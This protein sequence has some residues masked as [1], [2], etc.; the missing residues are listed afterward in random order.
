MYK[1][2]T[3]FRER[4]ARWK[5][6]GESQYEAGLPKFATGTER[7]KDTEQQKAVQEWGGDWKTRTTA[8]GKSKVLQQW[9]AYGSRPKPQSSQEY[10][11]RRLAE[12]QKRTWLSDAADIAGGVKEAALSMT[13]YTAVPYFGAKVGQDILNG[14]VGAQTAIDAAFTAAPFMPTFTTELIKPYLNQATEKITSSIANLPPTKRLINYAMH[15]TD[16]ADPSPYILRDL[17]IKSYKDYGTPFTMQDLINFALDGTKDKTKL[18]NVLKYVITGKDKYRNVLKRY[19]GVDLIDPKQGYIGPKES[20]LFGKDMD[21]GIK[22]FPDYGIHSEYI[23]KRPDQTPRAVYST[24]VAYKDGLNSVDD[25]FITKTYKKT[26]SST[27]DYM[28]IVTPK[29]IG[30]YDAGGHLIQLGRGRD[31][32][33]YMRGQDL[34][35][36]DVHDYAKKHLSYYDPNFNFDIWKKQHPFLYYGLRGVQSAVKPILVRSKWT[37][38]QQVE[39]SSRVAP[40]FKQNLRKIYDG[41]T[42][43]FLN[44]ME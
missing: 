7:W 34:Y 36:F 13:P 3:E 33:L 28:S 24:G 38:L 31:C 37:P 17:G 10:T 8:A 29:G 25:S 21:A 23:A 4:F 9:N 2:P 14:S 1:D 35:K 40:D 26:L 27:D 6:T 18:K 32:K 19:S 22:V 20:V 44:I 39:N 43:T 16:A 5:S 11:K 30:E 15:Q 12:E 42:D 41:R